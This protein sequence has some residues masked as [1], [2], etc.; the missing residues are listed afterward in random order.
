MDP[1]LQIR[2]QSIFHLPK[3]DTK[4]LMPRLIEHS[5]NTPARLKILN[6]Y[7][8]ATTK[9]VKWHQES[10]SFNPG[11]PKKFLEIIKNKPV[12]KFICIHHLSTLST[13]KDSMLSFKSFTSEISNK[14]KKT[15]TEIWLSQNLTSK[16]YLYFS[17]RK[18][19]ISG[20]P[21]KMIKML[22]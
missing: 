20:Q 4:P 21:P 2:V 8:K 7:G 17:Q 5:W 18:V 22:S 12:M 1:T 15:N 10:T 16:M 11:L 14:G 3:I 9:L 19:N 6:L 13:A